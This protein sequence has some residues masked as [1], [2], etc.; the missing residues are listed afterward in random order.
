MGIK[1]NV[2]AGYGARHGACALVGADASRPEKRQF[3]GVGVA[4][5][6]N[7]GL[8][9]CVNHW[10]VQEGNAQYVPEAKVDQ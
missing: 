1:N 9:N 2:C 10:Q 8:W 5:D 7:I 6:K 4:A 3:A